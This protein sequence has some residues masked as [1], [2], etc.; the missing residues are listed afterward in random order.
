MS[1]TIR[2]KLICHGVG[3]VSDPDNNP[4]RNVVFNGVTE[5]EDSIFGKYTPCA[6]FNAVIQAEVAEKLE[7]G[8]AYYFDIHKA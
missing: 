4:L 5:Q 3:E 7:V 8:Q 2:C 1:H 6:N